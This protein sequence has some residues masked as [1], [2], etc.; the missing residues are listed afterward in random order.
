MWS[1]VTTLTNTVVADI[2][3]WWPDY[4]LFQSC[5]GRVEDF[6]NTPCPVRITT[7]TDHEKAFI[8]GC[9]RSCNKHLQD[10]CS[11]SG[12]LKKVRDMSMD[13]GHS[14]ILMASVDD[15]TIRRFVENF[16]LLIGLYLFS[17]LNI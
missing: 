5:K 11:V 3:A 1:V 12:T 17:E 14:H 10:M 2:G 13:K 15:Y 4:V 7:G 6:F 9:L 8:C 16:P